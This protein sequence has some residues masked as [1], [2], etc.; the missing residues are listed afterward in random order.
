MTKIIRGY[1][2]ELPNKLY[3]AYTRLFPYMTQEEIEQDLWCGV[4]PKLPPIES[5]GTFSCTQAIPTVEEVQKHAI[6]VMQ[7]AVELSTHRTTAAERQKI[8]EEKEKLGLLK[9]KK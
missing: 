7:E 9:W 5:D 4:R 3:E 1:E 2:V 6:Q 8:Y